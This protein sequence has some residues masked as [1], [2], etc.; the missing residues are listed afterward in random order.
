MSFEIVTI[1]C[2]TSSRGR[3]SGT[4][5]IVVGACDPGGRPLG[6]APRSPRHKGSNTHL[7][8]NTFAV[9]VSVVVVV[10]VVVAVVVVTV[11]VG[12][13]TA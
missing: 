3:R 11:V 5:A 6:L 2:S 10:A 8:K 1:S 12:W 4:A 13:D 7:S 9:V